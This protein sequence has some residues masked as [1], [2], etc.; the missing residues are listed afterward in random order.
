MENIV[1]RTERGW[2]GHYILADRCRF[3]RNT[4]LE[5]DDIKIVVSSVGLLKLEDEFE[6]I[7]YNRYFE[8]MSFH[9]DKNDKRYHDIDVEKQ[10]YFDSDWSIN[11]IDADD[12]ANDMHEV[13]VTEITNGLLSGNK[14]LGGNDV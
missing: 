11:E 9:A 1:K 4:L 7:G 3:R 2:A 5:Y 8:T 6:T 13:V 10:V 14:Y 12:K